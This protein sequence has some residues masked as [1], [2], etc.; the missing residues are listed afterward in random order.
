MA[1]NKLKITA[2]VLGL[3]AVFCA[4]GWF[5]TSLPLGGDKSSSEVE[6]LYSEDGES[7]GIFDDIPPEDLA[8]AQAIAAYG[9]NQQ[10][11]LP[12]DSVAAQRRD[13]TDL[14]S[15]ISVTDMADIVSIAPIEREEENTDQKDASAEKQ[16]TALAF[17]QIRGKATIVPGQDTLALPE[18]ESKLVMIL[19]LVKF[20][21]IKNSD[22][23]K[24]FK[25]RARGDYPAVDFSK[26]MLLVLESDS[27]L[28]DNVFEIRSAELKDGKIHVAYS[29]SLFDLDKKLNT[30]AVAAV[31]RSDAEIELEQVL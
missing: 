15:Q 6:R 17:E 5:F 3:A 20:F 10:V 24:K 2:I 11:V 29:V 31:D 19:A 12:E 4:G 16:P 9:L 21:L 7:F 30:H 1:N 22:E 23:Y 28:P 27:Q 18:Q 13:G 25:T 14:P 26:Q 8:A